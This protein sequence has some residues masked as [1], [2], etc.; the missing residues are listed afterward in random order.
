M[1]SGGFV[2]R[3]VF[4]QRQREDRGLLDH[5]PAGDFGEHQ[6]ENQQGP[7]RQPAVQAGFIK[8]GAFTDFGRFCGGDGQVIRLG[9]IDDLHQVDHRRPLFGEA[10]DDRIDPQRVRR[11]GEVEARLVKFFAHA[12][13]HGNRAAAHIDVGFDR[14]AGRAMLL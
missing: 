10:G 6:A 13:A 9:E 7:R 12:A 8:Q 3:G 14:P 5:R 4:V 11:R 1:Q 2:R